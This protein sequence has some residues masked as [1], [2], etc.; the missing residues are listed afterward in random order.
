MCV[1]YDGYK[2]T[3]NAFEDEDFQQRN[4]TYRF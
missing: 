3:V 2:G 1:D 4:R